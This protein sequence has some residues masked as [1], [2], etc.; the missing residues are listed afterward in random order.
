VD[1]QDRDSLQQAAHTGIVLH[2][3]LIDGDQMQ[4]LGK[5]PGAVESRNAYDI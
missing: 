5:C 1:T 3:V 4:G 2:N